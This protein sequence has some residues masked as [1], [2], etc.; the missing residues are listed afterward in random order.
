MQRPSSLLRFPLLFVFGC[1]SASSP[2]SSS[3]AAPHPSRIA[4]WATELAPTSRWQVE[5]PDAGAVA[6][7][8]PPDAAIVV[9]A[10]PDAAAPQL[11]RHARCG[12]IG[13][14]D[15]NGYATFVAHAAWFDAIHPDWWAIA[16]DAVSLRVTGGTDDPGLLAAAAAHHVA[17]IPLVAGVDDVALVRTM[18]GDPAKRSAHVS[19]LVALAVGRGYAGLDIDYEHLWSNADRAPFTAFIVELATAMHAAGKVLSVAS[20]ALTEAVAGAA[21]SYPDLVPA[22]DRIHLMGYD[23][24]S[25]GTHAGPTAPLGWIDAVTTYV[26]A[27][28]HPEKFLLGLPNY[29]V[30]PASA[31]ALSACAATCTSPI[32]ATTDHMLTCPF[33]NFAPGRALNCASP[34]GKLFFDDSQSLEEKVRMASA[35]GLGGVT[36]WSVGGEPAGFFE[37]VQRYY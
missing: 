2:P 33:G 18:L 25:L 16:S 34:S 15:A 29:G 6:D 31:C 32:A 14:G 17:V 27:T 5:S 4:E 22:L 19:A 8:A 9:V 24:H 28:G 7:A 23:F 36:Y 37:M 30:T 1:T 10:L 3:V 13:A 26:A 12:W 11:P 20:P 21:W 35:R